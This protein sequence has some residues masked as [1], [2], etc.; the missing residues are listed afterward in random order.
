MAL[1]ALGFVVGVAV[2]ATGGIMGLLAALKSPSSANCVEFLAKPFIGKTE[3]ELH[4]YVASRWK[5]FHKF[6]HYD[7]QIRWD[8][9]LLYKNLFGHYSVL[10]VTPGHIEGFLIHLVVNEDKQTEF[11]LKAV[12]LCS[13]PEDHPDLKALSLGT[14][15][16]ITAKHIIRKAHDRL[17]NMG[18]YHTLFN[19]CQDYCHGVAKDHCKQVARDTQ[20]KKI[21]T[22]W[23]KELKEIVEV[24]IS[25]AADTSAVVA[26]TDM[27][28]AKCM[29][30]VGH[31]TGSNEDK[32]MKELFDYYDATTNETKKDV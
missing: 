23:N 6:P 25:E 20:V 7:E 5:S 4:K 31:Q 3:D 8:V 22:N 27:E 11:R 15:E 32:T 24:G 19:N 1:V 26:G 10:F 30:R 17:V 28:S 21:H 14:T 13:Y 18:Q 29:Q 9:Y 2:G 16:A 12:K